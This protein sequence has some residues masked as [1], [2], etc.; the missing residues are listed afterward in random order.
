MREQGLPITARTVHDLLGRLSAQ[1]DR[2]AAW[3]WHESMQYIPVTPTAAAG[4]VLDRVRSG[5][6][7]GIGG[8]VRVTEALRVWV[9]VVQVSGISER[10]PS[11]KCLGYEWFIAKPWSYSILHPLL[12]NTTPSI[13]LTMTFLFHD[14]FHL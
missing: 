9:H 7:G 11:S 5:G 6:L 14:M 3:L 2:T 1:D 8:G 12:I 10:G 13:I 4:S